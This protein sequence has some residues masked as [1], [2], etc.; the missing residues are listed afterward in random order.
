MGCD[1]HVCLLGAW[2]HSWLR[3]WPVAL[4][5]VRASLLWE[6]PAERGLTAR[7][8][9]SQGV[10][11]PESW[12][13]LQPQ[14][15]T[16]LPGVSPTLSWEQGSADT[17]REEQAVRAFT[18]CP[19]LRSL[20]RQSLV[21]PHSHTAQRSLQHGIRLSSWGC[22]LCPLQKSSGGCPNRAAF[23]MS[24]RHGAGAGRPWGSSREGATTGSGRGSRKQHMSRKG[25]NHVGN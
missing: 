10:L 16:P 13:A 12:L 1:L 14:V 2:T 9:A 21:L 17:L 23:L 8:P 18:A 4:L 24:S 25:E 20:A 19:S 15:F 11:D 6:K 3:L 7:C 22:R 5:S